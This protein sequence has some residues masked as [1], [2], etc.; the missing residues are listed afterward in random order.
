MPAEVFARGDVKAI[1]RE[2]QGFAEQVEPRLLGLRL[3]R[4]DLGDDG[5]VP[6]L[7]NEIVE[8]FGDRFAPMAGQQMLIENPAL[9]HRA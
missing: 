3:S 9:V 6:V 2:G 7:A 4:V 1:L 5:A 8:N